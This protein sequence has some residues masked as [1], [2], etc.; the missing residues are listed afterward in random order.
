MLL[1]IAFACFAVLFAA[2]LLTPSAPAGPVRSPEMPSM[3]AMPET[4]TSPA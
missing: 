4:G 2:W 1:I 3:G